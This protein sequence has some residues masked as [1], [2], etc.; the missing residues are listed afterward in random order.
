MKFIKQFFIIGIISLL[1]FTL[2]ISSTFAHHDVDHVTKKQ[3]SH[4]AD[5]IYLFVKNEKY[6]EASVVLMTFAKEFSKVEEDELKISTL[7]LE[8]LALSYQ[9]LEQ[10][11]SQENVEKTIAFRQVTEF[12]L[13][14]DALTTSYQ[15]L[16][17]EKET[18]VKS[19]FQN[20][21]ESLLSG[22]NVAFQTSLNEFLSVYDVLYPA[23]FVD[24]T[25]EQL[26]KIDGHVQFLDK[27]RATFAQNE[28]ATEHFAIIKSDFDAL[29]A[30][31]LEDDEADPSLI[32]VMFS[33][34]GIIFA[35]LCFVGWRKYKSEKIEKSKKVRNR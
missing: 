4:L 21:N 31:E 28:K 8:M 19:T 11:L 26:E 9:N 12:R 33:V 1:S 5:K 30:G 34:G 35:S 24:L 15:P 23:L 18:V 22:N 17:V 16:W 7:D 25:T 13:L 14:L 3:L 6:D 29:F 32:W 10:I 20:M 27:Y 2:N